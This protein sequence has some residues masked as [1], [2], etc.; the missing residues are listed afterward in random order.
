MRPLPAWPVNKA[1]SNPDC[2]APIAKGRRC[3]TKKATWFTTY[4]MRK[5]DRSPSPVLFSERLGNEGESVG[6]EVCNNN[7]RV[8][9]FIE[10]DT[11]KIHCQKSMVY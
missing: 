10:S 4:A 9:G 2:F 11:E 6:I 7:S 3:D 5:L 8:D 1:T